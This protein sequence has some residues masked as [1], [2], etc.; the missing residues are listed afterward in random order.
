M[1]FD[2]IVHFDVASRLTLLKEGIEN[3]FFH[4]LPVSRELFF[5]ED[6]PIDFDICFLGRTTPHR[7]RML[8]PLKAA[9]NLIHVAHGLR[10]E[11]ARKLMNRSKIVLN[12][13]NH[14]YPN[15]ENRVVQALYCGKQVFSEPLSNDQLERD[16]DYIEFVTPNDL[17]E[18]VRSTLKN[19]SWK[20]PKTDQEKLKQF[21]IE[22][23]FQMFKR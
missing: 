14:D 18:K 20:N 22:H 19:N 21:E 5:P 9:F 17:L 3:L 10:D 4:P 2:A 7:E 11:D 8:A 6:S 1:P 12:I 13:H 15:F 23:F 16:V